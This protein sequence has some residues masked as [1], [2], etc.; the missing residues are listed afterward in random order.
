ME[1]CGLGYSK[2]AK[3]SK[4]YL[5]SQ[6][7]TDRD[8]PGRRSPRWHKPFNVWS[9]LDTKRPWGRPLAGAKVEP[10]GHISSHLL[11]ICGVR[12]HRYSL[13]LDDAILCCQVPLQLPNPKGEEGRRKV[14][15][16][17]WTGIACD[18]GDA[19]AMWLTEVIKIP[20]RLVRYA[21]GRPPYVHISDH[22]QRLRLHRV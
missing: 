3:P 9:L 20:C 2:P 5:L 1:C 13:C 4:R 21:G 17:N 19:V 18:E 11:Q 7:C 16:W 22:G 15:C 8:S 10:A 14:R 12:L 6:A